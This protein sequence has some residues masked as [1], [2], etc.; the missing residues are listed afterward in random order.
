MIEQL[1][2]SISTVPI[3]IGDLNDS[4]VLLVVVELALNDLP[5]VIKQTHKLHNQSQKTK[6]TSSLAMNRGKLLIQIVL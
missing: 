6:R 4:R 2:G 5:K 3:L 1:A